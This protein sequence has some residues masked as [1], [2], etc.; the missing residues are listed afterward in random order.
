MANE[1]LFEAR[2]MHKAFGPTI[3]LKDVDFTLRRGEIRGLIGENGSGKSTIMSIA[4]GMQPATNGEM[5]YLGKPWRPQSMIESQRAGISMILQEA[6]TIPGVTVAQNLFAG[7]EG[8]FSRLGVINMRKMYRAAEALLKKFGV[9]HISARDRVD[10][11]T[12]ENRKLTEIVRCVNDDTQ[13]LVV[14]ETTTA[15]SLEGREILYRLIHQMAEAGK[16]VVFISHDMDEILE[17]CTDLTVL[18]DGD[19][20]G[21]LTRAEMDAPDAVQRIRYMMVGREI[22]EKYYREDGAPSRREEVALQLEHITFGGI[23]D[24]S[25]TLH[26]GEIVGIGGLSGCGMHEIGRAAYGL[27]KL[28]AGRVLRDGVE[29]KSCLSAIEHGIGYISKNRDTESLILD[30]SI[31]SNLVL[32]SLTSLS[33]PLGAISPRAEKRMSDEQIEAFR[34]K[35]GSGRQ[36]VSTLS[37]GNKQKVSF[38]KWMAKGSEV[39]IMDCPTRGVDIGVKQAM[40]ALIERMKAEGKAILMISEE[41]S[42]LIGM[43]DRILIMKDFAV[44][45]EFARSRDL[46]QTDMIEYMI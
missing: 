15:L 27:E 38:G 6:N 28:E 2:H 32:P 3:A 29:I 7:R 40:Y 24:F 8:E 46:K 34:I 22:G 33:G 30:A 14:D 5:L 21:H 20:I 12:F 9:T 36:Y 17:Q 23:R 44:L 10:A 45:K 4:S 1:V 43:A 26:K 18:R 11:L 25:L 39:V 42:E 19:I 13:I 31:Q 35:C 41:L 37:G 16:A